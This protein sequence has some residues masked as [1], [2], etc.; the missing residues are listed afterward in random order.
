[1]RAGIEQVGHPQRGAHALEPARRPPFAIAFGEIGEEVQVR[2]R[3]IVEAQ[4]AVLSAEAPDLGPA[5]P[6]GGKPDA[7]A[8]FESAGL[9]IDFVSPSATEK[10]DC[11]TP[12][13]IERR[14][15]VTQQ[16]R[17]LQTPIMI[18]AQEQATG[19][20]GGAAWQCAGRIAL[21]E[22]RVRIGTA[23][24][25]QAV[26]DFDA[27]SAQDIRYRSERSSEV[28]APAN[29]FLVSKRLRNTIAWLRFE[30]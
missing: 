5:S 27:G 19:Q 7:E 21:R 13:Q 28:D 30:V 2:N 29:L 6:S 24:V 22:N 23:S 12:Q 11:P 26:I 16:D 18:Q 15:S 4:N 20:V 1:M 17:I 10:I 25:L 3:I 14:Q 8:A 9:K